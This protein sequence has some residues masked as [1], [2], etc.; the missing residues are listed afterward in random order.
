MLED[1]LEGNN[2]NKKIVGFPSTAF[3]TAL[4][5]RSHH[6]VLSNPDHAL[7]RP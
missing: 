5:A 2:N 6:T 3:S 1:I 4:P 7:D